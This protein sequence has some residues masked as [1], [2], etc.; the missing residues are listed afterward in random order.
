MIGAS[1]DNKYQIIDLLGEGGFGEVWLAEDELVDGHQVAIKILKTID[2]DDV[3]PLIEEMQYLA[4]LD[5][6]N[7]VKFL[8]HFEENGHIHL[9]MEYCAGGNLGGISSEEMEASEVF[10]WGKVLTDTLGIVHNKNVVHHD[11]KPQNLLLTDKG[12]IKVADF[13]V[14]NRNAGTRV[15]MAP[16][17]FLGERISSG[18]GRID[19]YALGISMLELLMGYNPLCECAREDLLQEKI[20]HNFISYDLDRWAQEI[21]LK[22]THPTPERRFQNM[23]DFGRAI[24]SRHIPFIFSGSNIKAQR[25]AEQAQRLLGRKKWRSA[26]KKCSQAIQIAP[27][28]VSALVVA[29]RIELMLKRTTLAK[30]HFSNALR[31][32]P[33]VRVQKELGWIALEEGHYPQAISMLSDHLQ[34]EPTDFDAYNLLLLCFYNTARYEIGERLCD[35]ILKQNPDNNC[36]INN[37]FLFR[38]LEYGVADEDLESD[39]EG[40]II[41][42]F[43]RLNFEIATELPSGWDTRDAPSLKSKLLF[44][45]FR[46][47]HRNKNKKKDGACIKFKDKSYKSLQMSYISIG[48]LESN[49]I[50]FEEH[51]ISRRH[52][53]ILNYPDD[54]WVY[55]LSSVTGVLVD[56]KPISGKVFLD[57]THTVKIGTEIIDV[58]INESLLI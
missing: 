38:L 33:R 47:G 5:H 18:D 2:L 58:T 45:D 16:E 4:S 44:Q 6:P 22:A 40:K 15:Y 10:S 28:C 53:V 54:I 36:F 42:P 20:Q 3:S 48:R 24:E 37:R 35:S 19:V 26:E 8:H 51:G 21:L 52:A 23:D 56:K 29:G 30:E 25:I 43:A 27:E 55:D 31:I 12:T 17:L 34:R 39:K 57:G 41:S 49:H 32:N 11:I 50:S 46:F 14:A 9:V 7:I 13:G 1:L